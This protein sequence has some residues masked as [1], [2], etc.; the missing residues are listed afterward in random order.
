MINRNNNHN[1]NHSNKGIIKIQYNLNLNN[2]SNKDNKLNKIRIS[3]KKMMMGY[4]ANLF[5][6]QHFLIYYTIYDII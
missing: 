3:R 6:I 4:N 1:R 2:N 5:D